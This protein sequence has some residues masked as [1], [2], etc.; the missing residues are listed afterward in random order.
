MDTENWLKWDNIY[1]DWFSL[2]QGLCGSWAAKKE[3]EK[4]EEEEEDTFVCYL[5]RLSLPFLNTTFGS[6]CADVRYLTILN[7]RCKLILLYSTDIYW[8][9]H[10]ERER[11]RV[12]GKQK[13]RSGIKEWRI[14]LTAANNLFSFIHSLNSCHL[15][16]ATTT[17]RVRACWGSCGW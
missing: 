6:L 5:N 14:C 1:P 10:R 11:E 2:C 12:R 16:T 17:T 13:A 9:S 8:E 15:T 3:E 7:T 4:G